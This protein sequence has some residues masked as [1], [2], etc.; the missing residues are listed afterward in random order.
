MVCEVCVSLLVMEL[1]TVK[2]TRLVYRPGEQPWME[3]IGVV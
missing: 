2:R 1:P 3:R